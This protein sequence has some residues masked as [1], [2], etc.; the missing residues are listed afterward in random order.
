MKLY[1]FNWDCGRMGDVDGLFV[2]DEKEVAKV[3]NLGTRIYF[4]EILGKHSEI[5]GTLDDDDLPILLVDG[6]YSAS[7]NDEFK[8]EQKIAL[9][10]VTLEHFRDSDYEEEVGLDEKNVSRYFCSLLSP[11]W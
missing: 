8:Y 7:D 10:G 5:D 11:V 1:S 4:G 6:T 2:A 3:I 9:G